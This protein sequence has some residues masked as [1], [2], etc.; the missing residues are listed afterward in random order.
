M[1]MRGTYIRLRNCGDRIVRNNLRLGKSIYNSR[2]KR[3]GI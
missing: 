3:G 2:S 1:Q